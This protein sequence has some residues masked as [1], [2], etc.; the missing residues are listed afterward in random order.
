MRAVAVSATYMFATYTCIYSELYPDYP[1][2]VSN[3]GFCR[4]TAEILSN[5]AENAETFFRNKAYFALYDV[6]GF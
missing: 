2:R 1:I 4:Q 6:I 5:L 3:H